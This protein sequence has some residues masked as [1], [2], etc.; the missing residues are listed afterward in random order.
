MLLGGTV[1]L[2]GTGWLAKGAAISNVTGGL[3]KG[4]QQR[5]SNAAALQQTQAK[6][7]G[8]L[9]RTQERESSKRMA[10]VDSYR[11][12]RAEGE[13]AADEAGPF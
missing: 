7:E 11:S 6:Q 12:A 5:S 1:I 9:Q 4:M 3:S 2:V 10:K 13:K 8:A